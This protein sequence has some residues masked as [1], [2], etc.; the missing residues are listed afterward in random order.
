MNSVYERIHKLHE[1][2][3]EPIEKDVTTPSKIEEMSIKAMLNKGFP[4]EVISDVFKDSEKVNGIIALIEARFEEELKK[5]KEMEAMIPEG[6]EITVIKSGG[7]LWFKHPD[8]RIF[9]C[10][11][12]I[13]DYIEREK[14]QAASHA[15]YLKSKNN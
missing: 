14:R 8:N 12:E 3:G 5:Q 9:K 1:V 7:E 4:V 10:I 2:I 15:E 13:I 6:S 11:E